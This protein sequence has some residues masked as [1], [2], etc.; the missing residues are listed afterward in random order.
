[1]IPYRV[2]L[3]VWCLRMAVSFEKLKL[4]PVRSKN[5]IFGFIHE[6]EKELS[7]TIPDLI[8]TICI[9]YYYQFEHFTVCG[10]RIEIN[11]NGNIAT[12]V[13]DISQLPEVDS[14][15]T[16]YGFMPIDESNGLLKYIWEFKIHKGSEWEDIYIGIDSSNKKCINKDF[17]EELFIDLYD[18]VE[19]YFDY[20]YYAWGTDSNQYT[21]GG[22]LNESNE[23][24]ESIQGIEEGDMIKMELNVTDRTLMY[25]KNGVYAQVAFHGLLLKNQVYHLA[26][27]LESKETCIELINF[28]AM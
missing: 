4:V 24:E 18:D 6:T 10:P 19:E 5:L 3:D 7:L 25:Y 1:M 9:F 13:V 12:V 11:K 20:T 15:N 23:S 26:I 16:V 17:S 8:T 14:K 28:E 22:K 21:N 2:L 27:A